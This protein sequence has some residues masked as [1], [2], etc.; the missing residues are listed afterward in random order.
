M[1]HNDQPYEFA[2]HHTEEEGKK[3]RKTIWLIFW[4]LLA[5]TTVEVLTGIFW[6]EWGLNWHLVKN[7]FIFLTVGK[8][9][10]IVAYYMHLKH[11]WASFRNLISITFVLLA[12][13]LVYHV[14]TEGV[15]SNVMDKW[16]W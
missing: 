15:Y 8:A 5:I 11:E 14:I 9:Y 3:T 2:V 7:L 6:K 10:F 13:Y 1:E 12:L 16:L 4:V